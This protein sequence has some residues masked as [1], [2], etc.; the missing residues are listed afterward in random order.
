MLLLRP[1]PFG[2]D[3]GWSNVVPSTVAVPP[4]VSATTAATEVLG[5]R[6]AIPEGAGKVARSMIRKRRFVKAE[7]V[8]LVNLRRTKSFP[9]VALFGGSLRLSRATFG[10]A[11]SACAGSTSDC[12]MFEPAS[13]TLERFSGPGAPRRW[14]APALVPLVSTKMKSVLLLSLSSGNPALPPSVGTRRTKL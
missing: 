3:G 4:P 11:L 7:P 10:E 9:K 12:V 13:R 14:P 2:C 5:L 6:S 8:L 1:P